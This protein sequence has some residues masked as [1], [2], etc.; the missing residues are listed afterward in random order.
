[1]ASPALSLTLMGID[2]A[3]DGMVIISES[4]I[5]RAGNVAGNDDEPASRKSRPQGFAHSAR[6]EMR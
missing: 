6:D 2:D 3:A 5:I 4:V 1:M